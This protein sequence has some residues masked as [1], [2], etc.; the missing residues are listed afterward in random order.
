MKVLCLVEFH[1]KETIFVF[2]VCTNILRK[3][4]VRDINGG[5]CKYKD[6]GDAFHYTKL[7][8]CTVRIE[9]SKIFFREI[10]ALILVPLNTQVQNIRP[11]Q[12]DVCGSILGDGNLK[13]YAP[14]THVEIHSEANAL[15]NS[16]LL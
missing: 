3:Q 8:V 7:Y 9:A 5:Y 2:T 16:R 15:M 14:K 6:V 1:L 10:N 4:L 13:T 12:A 11:P